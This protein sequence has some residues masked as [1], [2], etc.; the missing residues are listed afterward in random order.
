MVWVKQNTWMGWI[1]PEDPR[2]V[3]SVLESPG[4]V[5]TKLLRENPSPVW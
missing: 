3:N 2:F 4:E 5:F 1:Q